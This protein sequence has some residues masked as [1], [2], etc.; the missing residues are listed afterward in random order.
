MHEVR[1]AQSGGPRN[2]THP[3][4]RA[5]LAVTEQGRGKGTWCLQRSYGKARLARSFPPRPEPF[6]PVP[7]INLTTPRGSPQHG[8]QKQLAGGERL[9][10]DLLEWTEM[11]MLRESA[12][13]GGAHLPPRPPRLLLTRPSC[14][15]SRLPLSTDCP[16]TSREL[17]MS[18]LSNSRV[19]GCT[20]LFI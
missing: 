4:L 16:V 18:R 14:V 8:A 11:P 5:P 15:D 19:S 20:Q 12:E 9:D 17:R 10:P 6:S 3:A 7:S 13:A 1:A 2:A